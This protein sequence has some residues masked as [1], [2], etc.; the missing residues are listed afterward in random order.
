LGIDAPS[1]QLKSCGVIPSESKFFDDYD[2]YCLLS[3]A[4]ADADATKRP[5]VQCG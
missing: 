5:T 4:A 1:S 3:P 2:Y